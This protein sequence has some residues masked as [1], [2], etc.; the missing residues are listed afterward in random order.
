MFDRVPSPAAL[1]RAVIGMVAARTPGLA[2]AGLTGGDITVLGPTSIAQAVVHALAAA[3][4]S[5]HAASKIPAASARVIFLGGLAEISSADEAISINR[6]AFSAAQAISAQA[7][8]DGGLFVTV[9]DTGGDFGLSGS[10]PDRAWLGGLAGLAR[11]AAREWPLAGVR[12]IDIARGGRAAAELADAIVT[13]LL[14]GGATIDA[15]LL[16]NGTRQ[17]PT[18]I[19]TPI[20]VPSGATR[21]GPDSVILAT[22]GGRGVTAAA[23][24]ELARTS[25]PRIILLG[26]TVLSPEPAQLQAISRPAELKQALAAAHRER[27]GTMPAP[28]EIGAQARQI[29]AAREVRKTIAALESAGAQVRYRAVDVAGAGAV[30][31]ALEP[32]CAEWGPVTT[33]VHG[34]GVLADGRI[35]DKTPQQFSRVFDTKVR[36]L[37]AVLSAL[38]S[39]RL[40]EV[41][42]FSSVSAYFGNTGQSD[43]AM[44]NEVLNQVAAALTRS[45]T[46]RAVAIG[47]GAWAG[48]MVDATLANHF[49]SHGVDLIPIEAGASAFAAEASAGPPGQPQILL[50]PAS[51]T[52]LDGADGQRQAAAWVTPHSHPYLSD[53]AISGTVVLPTVQAAEWLLRLG[54]SARLQN[55]SVLRKITLD[56]AGS[57]TVTVRA[58]G[59]VVS[60]HTTGPAPH[61]RAT[62]ADPEPP[63]SWPLPGEHQFTTHTGIYDG[64]VLFHGPALHTLLALAPVT[65][66]GAAARAIGADALGWPAEP[67]RTDVALMDGCLQLAV[68]W[69]GKVLGSAALPMGIAD[70]TVYVPGRIAGEVTLLVRAG[71]AHTDHAECDAAIVGPD[72]QVMAQLLGIS[73]VRRPR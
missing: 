48:G 10:D 55:L 30:R 67:S 18:A 21:I 45:G 63:R 49:H 40:R 39:A 57:A 33:L 11:T 3:G 7:E 71:P 70:V 66:D 31:A 26:R 61:F 54:D 8:R 65:P 64:H 36:G 58:A 27:T 60:L 29:T 5:A 24:I 52:S 4:L 17:I 2:I 28:A 20:P 13:E 73:L 35:K 56:A 34:A 23:L 14:T 9:Q 51:F 22:G 43:Y 68:L 59:A 38:D 69:A 15:G 12:A 32:I 42:L 62:V 37:H 44:A 16:A 19:A 1:T 72:G 25:R 53:H 47:W 6:S 41:F 46:V 50:T